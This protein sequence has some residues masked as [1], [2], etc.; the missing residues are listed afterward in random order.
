MIHDDI[1]RHGAIPPR[2]THNRMVE[3]GNLVFIAGTT[4]VN[5][6]GTTRQQTEEV[7]RTIESYLTSAGSSK[8]RILSCNVW[9]TDIRE[10]NQ[11]DEA[12]LAWI[13]EDA[14]PVRATVQA[15]LAAP[16]ARVEIMMIAAK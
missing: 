4:A 9:L 7:L 14:R 1:K 13:P 8:S 6:S 10:K 2:P 16:D 5:R 15:L 3:F 12:W 11:M